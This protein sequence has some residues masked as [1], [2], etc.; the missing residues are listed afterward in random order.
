[1]S[2][3]EERRGACTS[4]PLADQRILDPYGVKKWIALAGIFL[5][6]VALECAVGVTGGVW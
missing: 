4:K 5:C 6:H 3:N 2:L 1:M